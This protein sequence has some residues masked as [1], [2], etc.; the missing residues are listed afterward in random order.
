MKLS[1]QYV[2]LLAFSLVLLLSGCGDKSEE[3]GPE[4]NGVWMIESSSGPRIDTSLNMLSLQGDRYEVTGMPGK[5]G[6]SGTFQVSGSEITF[7]RTKDGKEMK[8]TVASLTE[9]TLVLKL[10]E[11]TVTLKRLGGG[12]KAPTSSPGTDPYATPKK[13]PGD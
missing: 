2:G 1:A 5:T 12:F 8:M 10:G 7:R 3:K 6:E 13:R 4:L 11:S 9:T